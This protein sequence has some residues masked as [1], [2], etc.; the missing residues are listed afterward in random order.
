MALCI[1]EHSLFP[2]HLYHC[3]RNLEIFV[4]V[5]NRSSTLTWMISEWFCWSWYM[6]RLVSIYFLTLYFIIFAKK[7][8]PN[9]NFQLKR[10]IELQNPVAHTSIRLGKRE[11][12]QKYKI[13]W[14]PKS[15]RLTHQSEISK[16]SGIN[17]TMRCIVSKR[18]NDMSNI[19]P[20]EKLQRFCT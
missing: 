15:Q 16:I 4:T 17:L 10:D 11:S 20:N 19:E 13:V 18:S 8:S 7:N 5:V 9:V 14:C 6:H 1:Y 3:G 2:K 12:D